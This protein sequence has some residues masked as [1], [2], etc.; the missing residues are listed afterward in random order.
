MNRQTIFSDDRVYRYTLWREWVTSGDLLS[1]ETALQKSS[2]VMFIGLNPSTADE[3][4][5]DPTIR[6]CIGFAKAWGYG[7][8]CMTNIFAFRATDPKVMKQA[9]DPV[10][11]DNQKHVQECARGAG[12][13]IAAW[14]T[15][16]IFRGQDM[17]VK[18]WMRNVGV[19]LHHLGLTADEHP[20]HP[21]YLPKN[22]KPIPFT[23]LKQQTKESYV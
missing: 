15:H 11:M 5:D 23:Q 1:H 3:T 4:K 7:A 12:V 19:D 13:V 18:Q 14:G 10:G 2:Y 20:K 16:G 21:L 8:L 22:L 6:R 17:H 9:S